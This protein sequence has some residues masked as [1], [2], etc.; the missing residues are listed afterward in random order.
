MEREK[1]VTLIGLYNY[2]K[3]LKWGFLLS[4]INGDTCEPVSSG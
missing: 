1:V 4:K 2:K 3:P